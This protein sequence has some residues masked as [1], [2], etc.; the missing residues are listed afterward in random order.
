MNY[1]LS[2]E[3]YFRISQEMSFPEYRIVKVKIQG[4]LRGKGPI[5]GTAVY[6]QQPVATAS[7]QY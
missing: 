1:F 5:K 7:L 3:I 6:F 4:K 2:N